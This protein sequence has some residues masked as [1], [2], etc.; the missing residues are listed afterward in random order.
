MSPHNIMKRRGFIGSLIGCIG[1]PFIPKETKPPVYTMEMKSVNVVANPRKIKA[2]WTEKGHL[3]YL[4]YAAMV[5]DI[6]KEIDN[7]V[8]EKLCNTAIEMG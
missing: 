3:E 5:A 2:K 7:E 4:L 1:I 6:Q 8:I